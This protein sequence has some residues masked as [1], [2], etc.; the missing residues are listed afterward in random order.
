MNEL[1]GAMAEVHSLSALINVPSMTIA[2]IEDHTLVREVLVIACRKLQPE[3]KV[4]EAS[5]GAKGV[6]L[7]RKLQPEVAFLDLMLPDGDGLDFLPE[8][9]A[10]S[11]ETRIIAL[12]SHA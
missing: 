3:A 12:T 7:C 8:I 5:N 4:G 2:V 10:E 6:E 1:V 11:P 9:L